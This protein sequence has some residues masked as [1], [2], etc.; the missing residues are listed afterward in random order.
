MKAVLITPAGPMILGETPL[1][2]GSNL[3]GELIFDDTLAVTKYA[4][5]IPIENGYQLTDVGSPQGIL[6]NGQTLFP[7]TPQKLQS[8]DLI[9]V[10]KKSL[11]YRLGAG[12]AS[13]VAYK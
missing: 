3:N 2:I 4:E 13:D 1:K 10:G 8:G 5:I 7:N 12:D 11:V 9:V 6:V